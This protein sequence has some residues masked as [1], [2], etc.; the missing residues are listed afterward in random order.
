MTTLRPA[1][2]R[3]R[4]ALSYAR[5]AIRTDGEAAAAAILRD[6]FSAARHEDRELTHGFHSYPARFHPHLVRT[7]LTAHARPGR[8]LYDPFGGSGT[9]LVAALVAGA[10]AP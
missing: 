6:A 8:V 4:R 2:P 7:L 5:G 3:R 1:T 10:R 9:T